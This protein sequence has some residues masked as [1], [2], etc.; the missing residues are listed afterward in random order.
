MAK[1]NRPNWLPPEARRFVEGESSERSRVSVLDNAGRVQTY[2]AS[3]REQGY[4]RHVFSD[5]EDDSPRWEV[6]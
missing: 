3:P 6:H 5:L 4:Y 2:S 1:R